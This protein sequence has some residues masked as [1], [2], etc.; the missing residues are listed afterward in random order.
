MSIHGVH[1]LLYASAVYA[2][3]AIQATAVR[4]RLFTQPRVLV[5]GAVVRWIAASKRGRCAA[6][7]QNAARMP[8]WQADPPAGSGSAWNAGCKLFA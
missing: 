7:Y 1:P 3:Y 6:R 4:K 8:E 2:V 5:N